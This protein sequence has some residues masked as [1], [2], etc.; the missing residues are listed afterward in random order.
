MNRYKGIL[1][2][3]ETVKLV[4]C[5]DRTPAILDEDLDNL[6]SQAKMAINLLNEKEYIKNCLAVIKKG[7]SIWFVDYEEG[8]IEEAVVHSVHYTDGR[9]ESFSVDFKES[10]DFDEFIGEAIGD[11]F[12]ASKEMAMQALVNGHG[13]RGDC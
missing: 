4:R 8:E 6:I 12:F 10:G 2:F 7:T 5:W 13:I 1:D 3:L 9:I 11:N